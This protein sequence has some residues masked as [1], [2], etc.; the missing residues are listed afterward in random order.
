[1]IFNFIYVRSIMKTFLYKFHM[2]EKEGCYKPFLVSNYSC[3]L[4]VPIG[5]GSQIIGSKD[6][7]I[8]N[9]P[10]QI[11]LSFIWSISHSW[12]LIYLLMSGMLV[13]L[14]WNISTLVVFVFIPIYSSRKIR[15]HNIPHWRNHH[16]FWEELIVRAQHA[17]PPLEENEPHTSKVLP[18]TTNINKRLGI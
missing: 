1:M 8:L 13:T 5:G 11:R 3:H 10:L 18:S 9:C 17:Y 14:L 7:A 12:D 4:Q 15:V 2:L 16:P 6:D